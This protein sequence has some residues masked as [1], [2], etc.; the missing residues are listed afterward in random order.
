[1]FEVS[2]VDHSVDKPYSAIR[3]FASISEVYVEYNEALLIDNLSDTLQ[4]TL[5]FTC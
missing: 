5:Y 1:M 4:N 3:I 2:F